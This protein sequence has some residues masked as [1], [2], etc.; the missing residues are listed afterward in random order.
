MVQLRAAARQAGMR[1]GVKRLAILWALLCTFGC[2][3]TEPTFANYA[4]GLDSAETKIASI[5]AGMSEEEV[6]CIADPP[7]REEPA[8]FAK[9]TLP[10]KPGC[11]A[12]EAQTD[13]RLL[14]AVRRSRHEWRIP[15]TART[16][17]ILG[18]DVYYDS[19]GIVTCTWESFGS[20]F[21]S[22]NS[23]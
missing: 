21:W 8:P 11:G 17:T 20:A 15:E 7:I 14:P 6:L 4:A 22:S 1:V 16:T 5:H 12:C 23:Y 3:K 18:L 10:M 9:G 13:C 2:R 19:Q